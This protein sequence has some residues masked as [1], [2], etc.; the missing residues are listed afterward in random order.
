MKDYYNKS[1]KEKK[2]V[3]SK[4][5]VKLITKKYISTL[6]LVLFSITAFSQTT[7]Y[8]NSSTGD[9]TTGDG[10]SVTPFKTF[11]KGYTSASSGDTLDLTGTF[12]WTDADETGDTA[13]SGYTLSKNL[14]IQ[15]QGSGSTI[16]QAHSLANSA[17][18][19]VL[20]IGS[21]QT[22]VIKDLTIRHGNL[23]GYVRG[24]GV[25]MGYSG[26]LTMTNCIIE[27]N[28]IYVP[29][30]DTRYFGG[31]GISVWSLS[32]GSL[33]LDKCQ[34]QNNSSTGISGGAG[35][36]IHI[37]MGDTNSGEVNIT[38]STFSNNTAYYGAAI[39][40][41]S[42]R[43]KITNTT[44]SGNT[45]GTAVNLGS[46]STNYREYAYLTNVTIA[47]N[48]LG[49][50]GYGIAASMT[51]GASYPPNGVIL[52]NTIIVQNKT[53]GNIQRD[54]TGAS[55]TTNN[56]YN[57][58]E[59][60]NGS[61]FTNGVNGCIVGVQS[62][63]NLSSILADNSTL[64]GTQTL[65]LA[66][67]SVAI[68]AGNNTANGTVSV[69]SEDQKGYS[70]KGT[71]DI[72]SF[73]FIS[74]AILSFTE[75]SGT[76]TFTNDR[77]YSLQ[78]VMPTSTNY[79][80]RELGVNI[81]ATSGAG[82][83]KMA[84]YDS[85]DNLIYQTAEIAVTGG[86]AEYISASIPSESILLGMGK[87]YWVGIIGD[88]TTATTI[89]IEAS[90]SFTNLGVAT[91]VSTA[92]YSK[93]S[94]IVY[95]TFPATRPF[96][97]AWYRSVSLVVLGDALDS[98]PSTV[99]FNPINGATGVTAN[100][101]ITITF[102]EAVRN[103]DDSAL[104][105]TNVDAL[106]TLKET[107]ASGS[108]IAFDATIDVDKKIITINPSSDFLSEQ[109]IYVAI[110]TAVEDSSD[111][112]ITAAN[113]TFSAIYVDVTDPT[114]TLNADTTKATDIANCFYTIQGT[115]LN[116]TSATDD[117]G[118]LASLTYSLQ[119]MAPNPNLI[120]EDFNSGTWD[121]NNFELGTNTG[122][123]V[124][125]AYKSDTSSRGTLRSV[126]EFVP[127]VG[128][129]LYVSATL[130]FTS[131]SGLAFF[132]TRSTG[133]QP[134]GNFNSEPDGLKFR[135]HNFNNGQTNISPGYD[136]QPRPG[137]AFYDNPVRFEIIDD[138]ASI[139]VTM[140]NL[141]TN[142]THT[143]SHNTA[144]TT[145]SNRVVFSGDN[146]V[147]WDDIKI[148]SG[149]HEYVQEYQNGSN[150]LTGITLNPGEN[151]IVWTA[152]DAAGNDVSK[153][154][155]ITVEDTIDPIVIT[156][157]ITITLDNNGEASITPSE[158]NNNS[159]DN[160]GI[161]TIVLDKQDFTPIDTGENTVLLT[162]TDIHGNSNSE[163]A[164]VTVINTDVNNDGLHDEAFVTTWKTDNPGDSNSTS[165]TLPTKSGYTYN[166]DVD[167]EG[168]GT[169]DEFGLTGDATHN[170]SVA[171]TYTVQIKGT[172]PKIYFNGEG[173]YEKIL[174][175]AQ[176]GT[177][178]WEN[179]SSA[180]QGCVNIQFS[181]TDAP[182]LSNVT[183]MI[184]MFYGATSF[185]S[186][187]NHWDVGNVTDMESMFDEA[188]AFNQDLNDWNV[189]SVMDMNNMFYGAMAFN[190]LID[191]WDV[192]SVIVMNSMFE[193]AS[194]FNQDIGNWNVAAVTDM[195]DMFYEA[196][197]FNQDIN[198]WNVSIVTDMS[199][200]FREAIAFNQNLDSW[201]VQNVTNMYAMFREASIFNGNI[202]SWN[203]GNVTDMETMFEEALAF[204]QNINSWDVSSVLTMSDMFEGTATFNQPLDNWI[205]SS[206]I[207]TEDMFEDA[208][209][210]NQP[211]ANWDVSNIE[212]MNEMFE[213]ASSF[214][215]DLSNWDVSSVTNMDSMFYNAIAFN[216]D[217]G[218][219]DFS[220]VTT[221]EDM[222]QNASLSVANYDA[223]LL[224]LSVQTLQ[225]NV[226]FNAGNS[227][228]CTA[229]LE[230]QFLIDTYGFTIIDMGQ[231]CDE[232]EDGIIDMADNCPTIANA[233]QAD[234]DMDGQ[235]DVCDDDDD[236]D[237]IPDTEDTFPLDPDEDT[238]TDDDGI[239]NNADTDDDDDGTP[240]NEDAFPLDSNEDTDTDD[241]GTGDNTDTDDDDDG[242]P[243]NEDAFPLDPNED[244]DTD[245][246]GTGNNADTDDD[247]DGTPDNEDAF[248]LDPNEDTDTDDDGTGDNE[249]MD[250]DGDG[251]A[252][253]SD[254]FPLDPNEDTDSDNDG[255][256]DNA[257][258]VSSKNNEPSL[259]PAEAFTP[260]G[261]GINDTWVIPDIDNYPNSIVRVYNRWGH[262]VFAAQGYQ[263]NWKGI[264]RSNSQKLPTGS[265]MYVIDLGN[266][267]APIQGWLFVN[268]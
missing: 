132:G 235:G 25:S 267:T 90:E 93:S 84:I 268:Y 263:N 78:F 145:G 50:S 248:P 27:K 14:T 234:N 67:G 201:N 197:V 17:D 127:T 56:G 169:F 89:A 68:D 192:S 109:V 239:G 55:L 96:N 264:Y 74:D 102:D 154:Q 60:Q 158:I 203:V 249:D 130:S 207:V 196:M 31:G 11:T 112:A 150:S 250:D 246:D 34:V 251:T 155:I 202:G 228:F 86:V 262:E 253:D 204:N 261:D 30:S 40:G 21:S 65:A 12:T 139:N 70:R 226:P 97:I 106:I 134:S 41:R 221:M 151:T 176:W 45:G 225:S 157:N 10:T 39:S 227:Q 44:I 258:T 18:R 125:G 1:L 116:P 99:T 32:T 222:F 24:A 120:S 133:E 247:D 193:E 110:G 242:T 3:N 215:Q 88:P 42:P 230:R 191:N 141:V 147:S 160:C 58:V 131:G 137:T 113:T 237:T 85:L 4:S 135:I 159:T 82:N 91:N 48:S 260:N 72:G 83:V 152:T 217:I 80:L 245:D 138:G 51:G 38:N 62:N 265:Y 121:T 195:H 73:E 174:T 187:I 153:S 13:V 107:N 66:A 9:D 198:S 101:N 146:S 243:D 171:G 126:A 162:I 188:I 208:I 182:D 149:A 108:D 189:S 178:A 7:I 257:D 19:K 233:D 205:M 63:L 238:D 216:Q 47:Y 143:Y 241:D 129:P 69:P 181:A 254:A 119:K 165:I 206:V 2:G 166:Y 26:N 200:M 177:I 52:K 170:Y 33:T 256:G 209:A 37:S 75:K 186:P 98:T 54:Y 8:V 92:S 49:T 167:W 136:Y 240:D 81:D 218:N 168:D 163:T 103:I 259:V 220:Q 35:G 87:T 36:G 184:E 79:D 224:G 179:M 77:F 122:S 219:W 172:F 95:P 53:T 194:N 210:F 57:L 105:D 59:V 190:G 5:I 180:F 22:V 156:Q 161:D 214:N 100:S 199:Y 183:N 144:Y 71:T 148:S 128:N 115:E 16:I 164:V 140:T 212:D 23:S 123:V 76:H 252:D 114:L 213:G 142:V 15:G 28:Y 61:T 43:I 20:S 231:N 124:N 64:N 46:G 118:S 244:T 173:D 185:N 6:F 236:N 232:D 255:I 223:L 211:I 111:N 266:G 229:V 29:I 175:V 117:S 104:T 94:G